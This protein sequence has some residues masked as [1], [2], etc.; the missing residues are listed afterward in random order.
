MGYGTFQ[1]N[2]PHMGKKIIALDVPKKF[3]FAR[4]WKMVWEQDVGL[5]RNK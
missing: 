3:M 1:M 4:F 2:F 5:I